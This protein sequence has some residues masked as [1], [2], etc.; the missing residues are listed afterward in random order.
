M[1]QLLH[2]LG[3]NLGLSFAGFAGSLVMIG[4]KEFSWKKA[5]IS[6]PSGVFSANYLT[7]I[8]VDGLGMNNGNAEYGIAFIM[9]Y[10]G[11]KGTE[12]V[13]NKFI[14]NEKP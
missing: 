9:G 7:P 5:I 6:I 1:K 3:I 12:I 13:S 8:V 14:K 10:L 2:D 11:L 4:K